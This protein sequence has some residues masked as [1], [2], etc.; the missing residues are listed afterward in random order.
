ME[1]RKFGQTRKENKVTVTASDVA[2]VT[3]KVDILSHYV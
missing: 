2:L 1:M 3:L